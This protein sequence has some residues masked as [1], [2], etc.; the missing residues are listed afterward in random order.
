MRKAGGGD[1]ALLAYTLRAPGCVNVLRPAEAERPLP[2]MTTTRCALRMM[3]STSSCEDEA[4]ARS[5][6]VQIRLVRPR[7]TRRAPAGSHT[8]AESEKRVLTAMPNLDV[9]A[10]RASPRTEGVRRLFGLLRGKQMSTS[11][12]STLTSVAQQTRILYVSHLPE[13]SSIFAS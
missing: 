12:A 11:E 13:P 8:A 9:L 10:S 3:A 7:S 1:P 2:V 6:M 5:H 4:S